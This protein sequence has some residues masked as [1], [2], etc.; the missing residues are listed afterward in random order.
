MSRPT[1]WEC[2]KQ[3]T[4]YM[5][6]PVFQT[7]VDPLGHEHKLHK[8]CHEYGGYAVKPITVDVTNET[9]DIS[10]NYAGVLK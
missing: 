5:G 7:Y 9:T 6:E 4:Y 2:G 10:G 1:C 3:L 8:M